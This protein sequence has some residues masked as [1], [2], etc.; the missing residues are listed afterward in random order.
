MSPLK[1]IAVVAGMLVAATVLWFAPI[2][3]TPAPDSP[4]AP[5]AADGAGGG[6]ET[7]PAVPVIVTPVRLEENSAT[8]RAVG[9]GEAVSTVTLYPRTAGEV[10]AVNFEPGQKVE[11]GQPIIRLDDA[12]EKLA[13]RLAEVR[14]SDAR[15]LLQRYER[16]VRGGGVSA[17]EVDNARTALEE[18]R[19]Q[20]AQAELA[21]ERRTVVAPFSGAVGFSSVDV[22]DRATETTAITTLD[23]PSSILID[24]DVPEAVAGRLR[25]GGKVTA[26]TWSFPGERFVGEVIAL[27]SRI[28][29]ETRS[30]RVRA[31]IVNLDDR[32]RTGMSFS[33][34]LELPGD[35]FPSIPELALQWG[36]EGAY[37]WLV[38][39]GRAER[40]PV[41]VR[42][43]TG[44]RVLA[45]GAIDEGALVVIEGVLRLRDGARVTPTMLQPSEDGGRPRPR[46]AT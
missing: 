18:A 5:V 12:E 45:E 40:V 35:P 7:T 39:D 37:V 34:T 30:L 13:V 15:Q 17:T 24:F 4:E 19:I 31:R 36:R 46:Q 33:V 26:T 28:A 20:L 23:D 14:I 2:G 43:R 25:I 10:V 32:L 41:V 8:V 29:A 16:A 1:Q 11:E 9:T 22:G 38:R 3:R 27:D 21:L 42:R 44:G 6:V